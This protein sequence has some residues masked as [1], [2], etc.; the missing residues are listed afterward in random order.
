MALRR[1]WF[2]RDIRH[3]INH[4][5]LGIFP[6]PPTPQNPPVALSASPTIKIRVRVWTLLHIDK[7]FTILQRTINSRFGGLFGNAPRN[8]IFGDSSLDYDYVDE[9][10]QQGLAAQA[11]P[12]FQAPPPGPTKTTATPRKTAPS[13]PPP[14][15]S[16]STKVYTLYFSGK[17]PGEYTTRLTT[18]TV[19][20][21]TSQSRKRRRAEEEGD[22]EEEERIEPTRV[23]PIAMTAPPSEQGTS[24]TLAID[25][26]WNL[27][28]L[29]K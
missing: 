9:F 3:D 11:R 1:Y 16:E 15:P 5:F 25:F 6:L 13:K 21:S 19:T 24:T 27:P 17:S 14:P 28:Q 4:D 10:D 2:C 18:V 23:R 29:F 8:P 20:P 7:G 26:A 22:E 12:V